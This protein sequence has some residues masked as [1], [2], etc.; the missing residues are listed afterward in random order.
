MDCNPPGS[1][2]RGILQAKIL[3]GLPWPPAGDLLNPGIGPVSLIS[4]ALAGEFLFSLSLSFFFFLTTE[5]VGKP[6]AS[7]KST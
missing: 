4:A 6:L 1:S 2:V 3:R 7:H 5:P